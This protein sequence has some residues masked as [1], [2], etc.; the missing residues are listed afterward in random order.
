M[1]L[2]FIVEK[3][4]LATSK[5]HIFS[6]QMHNWQFLMFLR[7][8]SYFPGEKFQKKEWYIR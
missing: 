2:Y 3:A 5:L 1:R 6:T 8:F 7:A 4:I